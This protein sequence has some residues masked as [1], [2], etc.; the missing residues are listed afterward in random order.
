MKCL[1][2]DLDFGQATVTYTVEG[3]TYKIKMFAKKRV[4]LAN[5]RLCAIWRGSDMAREKKNG[6]RINSIG[7]RLR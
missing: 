5:F 1:K 2:A 6:P 4:N 3:K 7:Q